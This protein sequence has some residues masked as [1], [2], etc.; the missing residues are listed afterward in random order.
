MSLHFSNPV[1]PETMAD[2]FVLKWNGVY[3][4][5][6]TAPRDRESQRAFRVLRSDDLRHWDLL[7][8]ALTLLDPPLGSAYW[9]P[10]VAERGGE[11]YMFYSAAS[12]SDETHR[13]RVAT[14]RAPEGP[15]TDA[16]QD[17]LPDCGFTI[18]ASPFRDPR[19]GQWYLYFAMDFLDGD[20]PGTG[21]AVVPLSDDLKTALAA[22]T[23][24]ARASADW[25]LYEHAR[26]HYGQTWPAWYTVEGPFTVHRGGRYYCFYSGGAW[27]G[28]DYGVAWAVADHP[29]GPWR[30]SGNDGPTIL[31]GVPGRTLGPGHNSVVIGPD[32]KDYIVYHAWDPDMTARRMCIDGLEWTDAGPRCDGPT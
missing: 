26:E 32:G 13:L 10:E 28:P 25:Q 22:P 9:A 31:R 4:A 27:H 8:G 1:Y 24:V 7:G 20:R 19:D 17:L 23:V 2:P 29:L 30:D 14:S 16:G 5:Y 18:D 15:F 12:G 11:F 3:Y 21:L 6:G